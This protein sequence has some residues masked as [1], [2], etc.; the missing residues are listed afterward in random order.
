MKMRKQAYLFILLLL[1]SFY[2]SH[3]L[4]AQDKSG[5]TY[6]NVSIGM[7]GLVLQDD[8]LSPLSYGG[9]VYS[10]QANQEIP[11]TRFPHLL[12]HTQESLLFAN[13]YNPS[14]TAG[15]TFFRVEF[16]V[17]PT[18]LW[19][20]PYG[21]KTGL[22]GGIRASFGTRIHSRNGNNPASIDAK[23]DLV[24]GGL[25]AYRLPFEKWPVAIRLR[26]TYGLLGIANSLA[27]GQSYYEQAF[28][29]KGIPSAVAFT[30]LL[31]TSYCSSSLQIDVPLW[32]VCTL[33]LGCQ[34]SYD[35]SFLNKRITKMHSIV[36]TFGIAFESLHFRG[37]KA[38]HNTTH[39]SLLFDTQF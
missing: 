4:S 23:S 31:N 33:E 14:H 18:Y 6:N 5:T 2:S 16:V 12:F 3:P 22:G 9:T 30:H 19:S 24:I 38:A 36:G 25:L 11:Y 15:I 39:P 34:W 7:G 29:G 1:F 37:R 8:Y 27:Y 17:T 32:N 21:I 13:T 35:R 10:L 26:A 20:L 28:I